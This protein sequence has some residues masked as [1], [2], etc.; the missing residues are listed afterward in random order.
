MSFATREDIGNRALQY[1]A[2]RRITAFSDSSRNAAEISFC[3]DK[4]RRAELRRAVWGF[5]VRTAALRPV[6]ST[7]KII[8]FGTYASGTTYAAGDIVDDG[9]G[10]SGGL[11]VSI[12]G[13]NTG[14][15]PASSPLWWQQYF[16]PV[17]ADAHDTALTYRLGELVYSGMSPTLYASISDSNTNH[18]PPNASYWITMGTAP[19][20]TALYIPYPITANQAGSS[21]TLYRLPNGFLRIAP[22]DAKNASTTFSNTGAGMQASD[23]QFK[24]KY[25]LTA[26]ASPILLQFAADIT[27]VPAMDDLFCEGLA[28]RIAL[29][30]STMLSQSK[31][32]R[33]GTQAAYSSFMGE[34][35][36][37]NAIEQGSTEVDEMAF[38]STTDPDDMQQAAAR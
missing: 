15:T 31:E 17:V 5:S 37:V 33:D 9:S 27:D 32:V 4:L 18:A 3:Y 7:T 26:T 24:N 13:S 10:G 11:Y 16:G 14:H 34:A 19:T 6:T 1:V 8:D 23:Y 12:R 21:R 20:L 38:R 22:Q 36:R 2:G 25:L 28:A 30:L 35:R 29:S